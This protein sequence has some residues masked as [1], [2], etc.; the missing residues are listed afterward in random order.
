METSKKYRA[1]Q[2]RTYPVGRDRMLLVS[3]ELE[4]VRYL[5]TTL[6][7]VL[8]MCQG[9]QTLDEHAAT[10]SQWVD[11]GNRSL[12]PEILEKLV[13]ANMLQ[14]CD[15]S[16]LNLL[17]SGVCRNNSRITIIGI[18]TADRPRPLRRSLNSFIENCR[19]YSH[20]VRFLVIDGSSDHANCSANRRIADQ[21]ATESGY[22]VKYLGREE[23]TVIRAALVK[24][25]ASLPT[26]DFALPVSAS[27]YSAGVN[28][29]FLSLL[30]AGQ[31]F[32]S[33][34]DDTLC[35]TWTLPT[36]QEGIAFGGHM[37]VRETSFFSDRREALSAAMATSV[38]L[39]ESHNALL[40]QSLPFLHSAAADKSDLRHACVHMIR[41]VE[42]RRPEHVVR[43][44][45]AGIAGDAAVHCPY[46]RLFSSG[47][48]RS[49][50]ASS[51]SVYEM[52][53]TSREVLQV[54]A[55]AS[56]THVS[57]CMAGCM[58]LDHRN[59]L[60][61]FMP[62]WRN[63]DGLF[64][65]TLSFCEPSA[66]FG[67]IPYGIV[68]DSVRPAKY[69][70]DKILS[71]SQTRISELLIAVVRSCPV[72][73]FSR[74]PSVR[75]RYLGRYLLELGRLDAMEFA[76]LVTRTIVATRAHQLTRIHAADWGECDYPDY[77]RSGLEE[78]R[79]TVLA[80]TGRPEFY[81]PVEFHG[82]SSVR[83][84]FD[85]VQQFVSDIGALFL[86]WPDMWISARNVSVVSGL[87]A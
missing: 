79:E 14:T 56:V 37:E 87:A 78:Y 48:T 41:A 84:G 30:T 33:V 9:C 80:G 52:A 2:F 44:T 21:V 53:L 28:R 20:G 64:G 11:R 86:S 19:T 23:K 76:E 45:F 67:H 4:G 60:P 38:D 13:V 82:R 16:R 55:R 66:W 36:R 57:E 32:L 63:E 34:D 35:V 24:D 69:N 50:M 51:R 22:E 25:G 68:H 73:T 81:L 74:S 3:E 75:M 85:H 40:G 70:N 62:L 1:I 71:A 27:A 39:L 61:P 49:R 58:A 8:G 7:S 17:P 47:P 65:V 12:M 77:W 42:E 18:I 31:E 59:V 26:L 72:A 5:E 10:I 83:E 15:E 54:A 46:Q 29:N 43:A 6:A